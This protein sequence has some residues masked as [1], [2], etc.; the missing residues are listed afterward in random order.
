MQR[1]RKTK[2]H[3]GLYVFLVLTV[4]ILA[5]VT[6]YLLGVK[7]DWRD[8]I[9]A[10]MDANVEYGGKM[11]LVKDTRRKRVEFFLRQSIRDLPVKTVGA[12]SDFL[13]IL[14]RMTPREIDYR[15]LV[16]QPRLHSLKFMLKG[17][18]KGG[19]SAASE[20]EWEKYLGDL[21]M[22]TS[23]IDHTAAIDREQGPNAE[24]TIEGEL[25]LQ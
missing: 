13:R 17:L 4:A 14:S 8:N 20:P 9:R 18:F 11:S 12:A 5:G 24:F 3:W 1:E 19:S 7:N 16:F 2:K 6:I 10:T 23:M 25:E 21:E 22:N 15:Q